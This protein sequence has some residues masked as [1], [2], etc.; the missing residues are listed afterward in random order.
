MSLRLLFRLNL[1]LLGAV[2][3]LFPAD[4]S[5]QQS[6]EPPERHRY[7]LWVEAEGKNQ[8][9]RSKKDFETYKQFLEK[10]SFTDLY[11]QVYRGGRSWFPSQLADPTPFKE[12]ELEGIDPLRDTIAIAKRKNERVHAWMNVLRLEK[13]PQVP[14]LRSVGRTAVLVDNY[15]NSLLDY[16]DQTRPPGKIGK[17]FQADTP[18][19][20]LDPS[21]SGV[22][23]YIVDTIR[24]LLV[25]YPELDGIHLDMIRYPFGLPTGGGS[26]VIN[27]LDFGYNAEAIEQFRA[28]QSDGRQAQI[29]RR[30]GEW[31]KFRRKQIT[32]LIQDIRELLD[33]FTPR[34]ELSIAGLGS[35]E[36]AYASAY[37]DWRYWLEQ[38][39]INTAV[40]MAYTRDT[41][42]V[43]L[44]TRKAI[45]SRGAGEVV[46]GL[47]AWM[48]VGE[49]GLLREQVRSVIKAGADGVVLFSYSNL[50]S[51]RG[52]ELL[53]S[54]S[55][56]LLST[57]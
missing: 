10:N 49:S 36:R 42:S 50:L 38:G 41:A 13:D 7:G 44:M 33:S 5:A 15:G 29:P 53:D 39:L 35:S 46:V 4:L 55:N 18:G 48:M 26:E 3:V 25:R 23:R 52:G 32:I 43:T 6:T 20:W 11:C 56:L 14:I 31:D 57:P 51:E 8:P 28:T 54:A 34:K 12:A 45:E 9:F 16:E 27:A 19:L 37:Q 17:Y 40:P 24:E 21:N 47:G 2:F 1:S 22:R 30:G